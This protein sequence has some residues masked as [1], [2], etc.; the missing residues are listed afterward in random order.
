MR[1]F[2][3]NILQRITIWFHRRSIERTRRL[4]ERESLL[5]KWN[6]F[7]QDDKDFIEN[8]LEPSYPFPVDELIRTYDLIR[9]QGEMEKYLMVCLSMGIS[10]PWH[11]YGLATLGRWEELAK[12]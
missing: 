5:A 10:S 12:E 7:T 4:L 9:D 6:S 3:G 8:H 2:I 1:L 11:A